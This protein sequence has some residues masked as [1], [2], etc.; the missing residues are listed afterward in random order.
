[1]KTKI[2]LFATVATTLAACG[3]GVSTP[4]E[5]RGKWGVECSAPT[6]EIDA[7]A[8]HILYPQAQ[9]FDLTASEFDGTTLKL[10]LVNAG[11][12]ITDVYTYANGTLTPTNVIVDGQTFSG[13]K[14]PLQK[15]GS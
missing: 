12:K 15:C 2:I 1:M 11:K 7:S 4:D 14:V 6:I 5:V 3:G 8:L 9:D 10:S 13:D